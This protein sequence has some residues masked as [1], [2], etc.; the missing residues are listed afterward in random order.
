MLNNIT[1]RARLI[2]RGM[3]EA[4]HYSADFQRSA[5]PACAASRPLR[6]SASLVSFRLTRILFC[7]PPLRFPSSFPF[8]SLPLSYPF[9]LSFF[10]PLFFPSS[11][12]PPL[13]PLRPFLLPLPSAYLPPS[14]LP[15]SLPCLP[16]AQ[17]GIPPSAKHALSFVPSSYPLT[18]LSLLRFLF[19]LEVFKETNSIIIVPSH[20][21]IRLA[22]KWDP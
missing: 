8:A 4:V 11:S 20:V 7:L 17:T 18:A 2:S 19:F 13:H 22:E 14:P 3:T 10:P 21:K 5:F 12:L 16:S 9:S 6:R 1:L 15:P